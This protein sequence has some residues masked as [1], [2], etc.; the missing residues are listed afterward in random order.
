MFSCSVWLHFAV[1]IILLIAG[2]LT[3]AQLQWS[4]ELSE[5]SAGMSVVALMLIKSFTTLVT[6]GFAMTEIDIQGCCQ[7]I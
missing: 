4:D 2:F 7:V 3:M 6:T 5:P 1:A